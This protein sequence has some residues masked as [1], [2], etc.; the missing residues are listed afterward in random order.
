MATRRPA[1]RTSRSSGA[2][3]KKGSSPKP[4]RTPRGPAPKP[5][6]PRSPAYERRI[7]NAIEK[8]RREGRRVTLQEARRGRARLAKEIAAGGEAKFRR[9]RELGEAEVT[10]KLTDRDK[11]RLRVWVYRQ[12]A[13]IRGAE[14]RSLWEQ[15]R[16][17]IIQW[18]TLNGMV[19]FA[20]LQRRVAEWNARGKVGDLASLQ[21]ALA[22]LNL[23]TE[24]TWLG[25]YL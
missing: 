5:T 25:F 13:R 21:A 10:G 23:P 24:L 11:G 22:D 14:G 17:D 4:R 1:K 3:K 2:S 19:F 12:A 7:A 15:Y 16:A 20:E 6:R 18:A 8:G 9:K